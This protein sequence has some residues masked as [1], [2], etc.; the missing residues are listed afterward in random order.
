MKTE[1]QKLEEELNRAIKYAEKTRSDFIEALKSSDVN[2]SG[3]I[4]GDKHDHASNQQ[5]MARVQRAAQDAV[6]LF[7]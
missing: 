2:D 3:R 6:S 7:S 5:P 4:A 1:K